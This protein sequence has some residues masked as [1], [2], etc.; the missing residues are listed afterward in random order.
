[1]SHERAAQLVDAG[2]WLRLSGDIEG[3]RRLFEQALKLDPQ[4]LRAAEL[5]AQEAT[6]VLEPRSPTSQ[7]PEANPFAPATLP[8][9]PDEV[10]WGAAMSFADDQ[11]AAPPPSPVMVGPP[12]STL[13]TPTPTPPPSPRAIS[14]ER[15]FESSPTPGADADWSSV[16]GKGTPVP[17]Q[18]PEVVGKIPLGDVPLPRT[19]VM[20]SLTPPPFPVPSAPPEP[21]P[22]PPLPPRV[23]ATP[24]PS[25]SSAFEPPAP[26]GA[27]GPRPR[28]G[29]FQSTLTPRPA[30]SSSFGSGAAGPP[31]RAGGF[32]ST[33]TPAAARSPFAAGTSRGSGAVSQASVRASGPS[34]LPRASGARP[35]L[36]RTPSSR[37]SG[38]HDV[39]TQPGV[40]GTPAGRAGAPD[41]GRARGTPTPAPQPPQP[42][43][44]PPQWPRGP[45]KS[46]QLFIPS[47]VGTG[48]LPRDP[49]ALS[50]VTELAP[51]SPEE[52]GGVPPDTQPL[53]FLTEAPRTA[54]LAGPQ[55]PP[56][57]APPQLPRSPASSS[58]S[59]E[60]QTLPYIVT[61]PP[62]S[63]SSAE[64]VTVLYQT[65]GTPI[66]LEA[67]GPSPTPPP[68]P[69]PPRELLIP[70]AIPPVSTPIPQAAPGRATLPFGKDQLEQ[71][72]PTLPFGQDANPAPTARMTVMLQAPP[73]VQAAGRST[74]PYSQ[75]GLGPP[76]N[77]PG[78]ARQDT[79]YFSETTAGPMPPSQT[80]EV[81][82]L[83]IRL[84]L[85]ESIPE[86]RS[87]VDSLRDEV[88]A[89]GRPAARVVVLTDSAVDPSPSAPVA[90]APVMSPPSPFQR[91]PPMSPP[92][93]LAQPT[94]PGVLDA[95]PPPAMEFAVR[96]PSPAPQTAPSDAWSWS[97]GPMAKDSPSEPVAPTP[98][99]SPGLTPQASSA[100][101][102][103]GNPGIRI[104]DMVGPDRT[105]ELVG[106]TAKA[107]KSP[108]SVRVEVSTLLAG[109]RDLMDLD[110]HTGAMELIDKAQAIAPDDPEVQR[111]RERSERTLLAMFESK[112]GSLETT[113]RVMLKDDEIIWLNLDHRAGF[114]LAQIDGTVTYED[115][116]AVSGMSRIDTARILAQLVDEGVISR[117]SAR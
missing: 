44:P 92:S 83:V 61:P 40:P 42:Q 11:E 50:F 84:D 10:D 31:A 21:P 19:T 14:P 38:S 82:P 37:G 63:G 93:P 107:P 106:S 43:P 71:P 68:P 22:A 114:V 109:A 81:R 80:A 74:V 89:V 62:V 90:P 1:M 5:L 7:G 47:G 35:P 15:P 113:P 97:A 99:P 30:P 3:A 20:F 103:R 91:L 2:I 94:P 18:A 70:P 51:T 65:T 95:D 6:E 9:P 98:R 100:W 101:D 55:S 24:R 27:S 58:P 87:I 115:L 41:A 52:V 102:L 28:G 116:F 104:D 66:P 60:R 46:T 54:P 77:A 56:A 96:S 111:L 12:P 25:V 57:V 8:P 112:L 49:T 69:L 29:G 105:L 16:A 23:G 67:Y 4:N 48:E 17:R 78:G 59:S 85:E 26:P 79:Q 39:I 34:P 110:D 13:A 73:P 86:P 117:G 32:R 72:R 108:D 75:S 33:L 45:S 53:P 36:A 64:R 88:D 76:A